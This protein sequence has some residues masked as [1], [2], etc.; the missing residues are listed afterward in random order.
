MFR[1]GKGNPPEAAHSHDFD[2]DEEQGHSFAFG[3]YSRGR[4]TDL[5]GQAIPVN[6]RLNESASARGWPVFPLLNPF[7]TSEP[8]LETDGGPPPQSVERQEE[9]MEHGKEEGLSEHWVCLGQ[10][11]ERQH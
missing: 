4:I 9:K 10:Q 3:Y 5:S 7:F 1:Y 6:P 2:N 11:G 8:T